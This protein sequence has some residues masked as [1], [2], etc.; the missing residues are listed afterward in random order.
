[1]NGAACLPADVDCSRN[2]YRIMPTE[3]SLVRPLNVRAHASPG[4]E[5]ILV[6]VQRH[7]SDLRAKTGDSES[8]YQFIAL[9]R[10]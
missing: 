8:V 5:K 6:Q 1:M 3:E 10:H 9:P 7:Y 4:I 2:N